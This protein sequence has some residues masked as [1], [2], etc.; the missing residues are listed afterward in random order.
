MFREKRKD[1]AITMEVFLT[2]ARVCHISQIGMHSAKQGRR[3][4]SRKTAAKS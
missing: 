1:E 3:D 4:R 2:S